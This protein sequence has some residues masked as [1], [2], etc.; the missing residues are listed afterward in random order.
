MISAE[1]SNFTVLS[2]GRVVLWDVPIDVNC[3]VDTVV[4]ISH[5]QSADII[6]AN[7]ADLSSLSVALSWLSLWIVFFYLPCCNLS[8]FPS[9]GWESSKW[10]WTM[11]FG[12]F[13]MTATFPLSIMRA[14][15]LVQF[16]LNKERNAFALWCHSL[17]FQ[18]RLIRS[19]LDFWEEG[20]STAIWPYATDSFNSRLIV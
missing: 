8:D 15:W 16:K 6:T 19:M 3:A 9:N 12:V 18:H 7:T 13:P 10:P 14:L 1:S 2:G 5:H 17:S 11:I 4:S 20:L